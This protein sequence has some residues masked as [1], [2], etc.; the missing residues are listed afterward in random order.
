MSGVNFSNKYNNKIIELSEDYKL[1]R[2]EVIRLLKKYDIDETQEISMKLIQHEDTIF[3]LLLSMSGDLIKEF[4]FIDKVLK[5][6]GDSE[7][8]KCG[9]PM[10]NECPELMDI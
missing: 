1:I 3:N 9:H 4:R 5:R 2:L 10:M 8:K 6:L 7:C